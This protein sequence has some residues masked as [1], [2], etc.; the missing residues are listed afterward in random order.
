[1]DFDYSPRTKEL[2]ARLLKFMDDHIY[3]NEKAINDELETN[4]KTGKR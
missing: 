2:Q 3:P 1:M 4:T